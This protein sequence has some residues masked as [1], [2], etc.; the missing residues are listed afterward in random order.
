M[1][2]KNI[3]HFIVA[4]TLCCGLSATFTACSDWSD[5]YEG[6]DGGEGSG[7]TLWEQLKADAQLSDFCEVLEQTKVFRMHKKTSI[8]YAELLN[9]GEAFT[10]VAPVNGTFDKD[11]YLQLVQ[12]N[13]GDSIVE[14]FFVKNHLS[15]VLASL[16]PT[17]KSML[18][19]N[20]KHVSIGDNAIEGV[21]V[22]K[23]NQRA[24]NGVLHV[25]NGPLPYRYSLYESLCDI[26]EM[27]TVGEQ[28]RIYDEDY[29]DADASVSSG[30]VEGVPVYVDSVV[31]ERNRF[32]QRVGLLAAEDSTYWVVSPS[33]T[34]WNEAWAEAS[35]YFQYDEKVLKRDS[36]N[37]YWTTYALLSDGVFNMTD[38]KSLQAIN[39]SLISVPYNRLKPEYHVFY[40]PFEDGGI[41]SKATPVDCSNGTLYVTEK[42][43]FTPEQTY[44]R[45]LWSEAEQTNLITNYK[46]CTYD[47]RRVAADS[48]SEGAY[49]DIVPRTSTSNWEITF[50]VNNTLSGAYDICAVVLP[51]SVADQINPDQ[52]KTKFK[53]FINYVDE[54]GNAKTNNC[55]NK[56]F[57]NDPLRVDTIVLAEAFKFP[58]CNYD[59]QDIKVSVR[60]LCSIT[61]RQTSTYA[62]EMYLDCI[63]LRPRRVNE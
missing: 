51:K 12:T 9:S 27:N 34:G 59:Q 5:H 40:K 62:R 57:T 28:L 63:Y 26:P 44:F 42:W 38:Q 25:V 33:N 16:T 55:G 50:K 36:L 23:A 31:V 14:K 58:A 1:I 4:G 43:P 30:I 15:G 3:K 7:A 48:I 24:K 13:Q 32:L 52:R 17:E 35:T 56:E 20:S 39:D 45:K 11:A 21:T 19:L 60:L 41:L 2:T 29:F 61:A 54:K 10:V 49:L 18:L 53:A 6:A 47:V 46:D 37:H 22:S 8:S